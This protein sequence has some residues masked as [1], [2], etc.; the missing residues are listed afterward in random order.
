MRMQVK[1]HANPADF[2]VLGPDDDFIII[3]FKELFIFCTFVV[4]S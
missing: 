4:A 2:E 1:M 3:M